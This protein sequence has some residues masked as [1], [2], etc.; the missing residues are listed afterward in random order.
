MYVAR[1]FLQTMDMEDESVQ[2]F[3]TLPVFDRATV[4][5]IADVTLPTGSKLHVTQFK[6]R[7]GTILATNKHLV[8][9]WHHG[10]M[11]ANNDLLEAGLHSSFLNSRA[12]R[13]I[14]SETISVS[15]LVKHELSPH[16]RCKDYAF[17]SL[18]E[19][20]DELLRVNKLPLET[21]SSGT[22]YSGCTNIVFLR[23]SAA[24]FVTKAH[25][26]RIQSTFEG[27]P[28]GSVKCKV[29]VMV[30]NGTQMALDTLDV[31]KPYDY[32]SCLTIFHDRP[33]LLTIVRLLSEHYPEIF[34]SCDMPKE[35]YAIVT[36]T[37]SV[38]V[39]VNGN[40]CYTHGRRIL[41]LQMFVDHSFVILGSSPPSNIR[42]LS[43]TFPTTPDI[44][45]FIGTV[46]TSEN[47]DISPEVESVT[48]TAFL[49]EHAH[50]D[51]EAWI[52]AYIQDE[53][54]RAFPSHAPELVHPWKVVKH[55]LRSVKLHEHGDTV[56]HKCVLLLEDELF[57]DGLILGFARHVVQVLQKGISS[58]ALGE[59]PTRS[60]CQVLQQL[61]L[62]Y[63]HSS[64]QFNHLLSSFSS[65][66]MQVPLTDMQSLYDQF[67]PSPAAHTTYGS[68]GNYPPSMDTAIR[69]VSSIPNFERL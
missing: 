26:N 50:P 14:V 41:T 38:V 17:S 69:Q 43:S 33:S 44:V 21:D 32:V 23:Q 58:L 2:T 6:A 36:D 24:Q 56:L 12:T 59:R 40:K 28:G 25:L 60:V 31:C 22:P 34:Q 3:N 68:M 53:Y 64:T 19:L 1:I 13:N 7:F 47:V 42:M 29:F 45:D 27:L 46:E 4:S 11:Q 39:H 52:L 62:P 54:T 9:I 55:H 8:R 5:V 18:S 51:L 49:N 57:I 66:V 35:N 48:L 67:T 15:A 20:L 61:Y 63:D 37:P 10:N 65:G 30:K 16:V